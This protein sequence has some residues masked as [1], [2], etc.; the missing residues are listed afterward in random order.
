MDPQIR[1]VTS[2]DGTRIAVHS[3]GRGRPLVLLPTGWLTSGSVYWHIPETRANLERLA[4]RHR[5]AQYDGRGYGLSDREVADYSLEARLSDLSAVV[6]SLYAL[7]TRVV[8]HTCGHHGER[9]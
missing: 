6:D 4:R 5:L 3:V 8:S 9:P 2:A 1:Y 7:G